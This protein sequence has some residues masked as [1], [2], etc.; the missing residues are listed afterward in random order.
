MNLIL[1]QLSLQS[2]VTFGE[3]EVAIWREQNKSSKNE[4]VS[5]N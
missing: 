2:G 4:R 1:S 3:N 5:V